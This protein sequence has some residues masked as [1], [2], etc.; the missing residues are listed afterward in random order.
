MRLILCLSM[1]FVICGC[2]PSQ[3]VCV[4]DEAGQPVEGARVIVVKP[5]LNS[6]QG[7]TDKK[8]ELEIV[9]EGLAVRVEKKGYA[10]A[11]PPYPQKWPLNITLE[12]KEDPFGKRGPVM[13][14]R[15]GMSPT[16]VPDQNRYRF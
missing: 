6:I 16:T 14:M 8:G 3:L 12:K 10:R 2:A 13:E 11:Y 15:P 5:S 7:Q 4:R 9:S 1:L